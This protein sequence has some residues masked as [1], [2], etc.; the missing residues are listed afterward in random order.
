[1]LRLIFGPKEEEFAGYWRILYNEELHQLLRFPKYCLG[2]Q[3][4]EDEM[5][6]Q[7]ARMGEV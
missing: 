3:I 4:R 7:V 6:G 2:D 5:D 1:V